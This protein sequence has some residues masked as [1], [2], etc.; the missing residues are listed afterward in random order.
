MAFD[1][2]AGFHAPSSTI[3]S[4][5]FR[6]EHRLVQHELKYIHAVWE[7]KRKIGKISHSLFPWLQN[8]F[9]LFCDGNCA[10]S[11][12]ID[13]FLACKGYFFKK[14]MSHRVGGARK[15]CNGFFFFLIFLDFQI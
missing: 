1:H 3:P 9:F 13:F 12:S 14:E 2:Q 6:F 4:R 7:E 10:M 5:R 11:H 15:I 8:S